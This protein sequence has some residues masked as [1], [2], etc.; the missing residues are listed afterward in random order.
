MRLLLV[1]DNPKL[2]RSISRGLRAEGYAVDVA[3]DGEAALIHAGVWEYDGVILDLM[4]PI[5]DGFDVCRSLRQRESWVP[6]LML[7]ARD[8][9]DDR[10]TGLD[11]G[12]DDYLAKP[13]DFGEFLARVR[14]LVRRAPQERATRI[15][16]G[17]LVL[18]PATREV[19]RG[20]AAIELT[21]REFAV[22][23]YLAR[24]APQVVSRTEL[25]EHVWDANFDGSTNVVDVH[26]GRLRHKLHRPSDRDSVIQTVRGVGFI[27]DVPS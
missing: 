17:D 18:D 23:E 4:L 13:F 8:G 21:P 3:T 12:A 27:L 10:I 26:V 5:R 14:A 15:V 9:V 16:R 19:L 2:V 7:T 6:I 25:L 1:E 24:R 22:L 20:A 11:A